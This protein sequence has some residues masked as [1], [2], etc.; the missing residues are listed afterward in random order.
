M[1]YVAVGAAVLLSLFCLC[2]WWMVLR[3]AGCGLYGFL[4]VL[5]GFLTVLVVRFVVSLVVVI[6]VALGWAFWIFSAI[7]GLGGIVLACMVFC[8]LC[9]LWLA[10]GFRLGGWRL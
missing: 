1:R 3:L 5:V 7:V 6:V 9:D 2:V 8:A 10:R 4:V